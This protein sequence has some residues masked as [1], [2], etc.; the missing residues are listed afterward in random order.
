ME[1]DIN[2]RIK[3]LGIEIPKLP[4]PVFS[5]IPGVITGNLVYVS[6]Q[7]PTKDG[8]LVY[9]GKVGGDLKVEDGYEAAKLA[10]VNCVA[11]LKLVLG[12]LNR[13]VRIVNLSGYVASEEGFV[14]QPAVV[15]GASDLIVEIWGEKGKHSRKAIGVFELPSGAPVEIELIAEIR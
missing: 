9:K 8:E 1:G 4:K 6:G 3:E 10:A 15:N 12:D 11:E 13:V 14:Q 5:Y 2:E 7:T